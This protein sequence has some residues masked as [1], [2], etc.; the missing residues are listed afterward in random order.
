MRDRRTARDAM[1]EAGLSRVVLQADPL[2]ICGR[3]ARGQRDLCEVDFGLAAVVC[4]LCV[5][6]LL[7][8]RCTT[9]R[10]PSALWLPFCRTQKLIKFPFCADFLSYINGM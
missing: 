2:V 1:K 8:C 4:P 6:A 7:M 3:G 5:R 10:I 9:R